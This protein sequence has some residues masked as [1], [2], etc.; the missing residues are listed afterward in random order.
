MS[1]RALVLVAIALSACG[2]AADAQGAPARCGNC[3]MTVAPTSPWRA[4]LVAPDG[5]EALFDAPKCMIE[6]LRAHPGSRDA[7]AI[8]YY[9][10]E[11]RPAESLF[12]V[13]GSDVQ[14][15][16]GRDLVPIAGR[17]RAERFA[18][19]HHGTRVLAWSEID[20]ATIAS[21]FRPGR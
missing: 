2:Q 10:A 11:R 9:S 17:D 8:D 14:G 20:D 3:G 19:D 6:W 12:F 16:M 15:P 7:W 13:L 18:R 5:A 4:G 21:L 1:P